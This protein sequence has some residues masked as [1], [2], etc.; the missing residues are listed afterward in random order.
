MKFR[1]QDVI[2][3]CRLALQLANRFERLGVDEEGNMDPRDKKLMESVIKQG[4]KVLS[5]GLINLL[6]L[7]AVRL[8]GGHST[9]LAL[10]RPWRASKRR[11]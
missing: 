10:G 6:D 2:K 1:S 7:P 4:H 9:S 3:L 11:I 5:S 8:G